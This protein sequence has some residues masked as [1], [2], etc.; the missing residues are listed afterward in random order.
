MFTVASHGEPHFPVKEGQASWED[1]VSF[2]CARP[3][4]SALIQDISLHGYRCI[5]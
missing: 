5:C 3:G 4:W 2:D 1:Q